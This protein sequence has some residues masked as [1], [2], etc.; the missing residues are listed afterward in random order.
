MR[1]KGSRQVLLPSP[2]RP[3]TRVKG[4][5]LRSLRGPRALGREPSCGRTRSCDLMKRKRGGDEYRKLLSGLARLGESWL[6]LVAPHSLHATCGLHVFFACLILKQ[7]FSQVRDWRAVALLTHFGLS[8]AYW[9]WY[10]L[11]RKTEVQQALPIPKRLCLE[12]KPDLVESSYIS[13][14]PFLRSRPQSAF[15]GDFR[16][17]WVTGS[18]L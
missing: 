6:S 13:R 5:G 11:L 3:C 18:L 7:H 9:Y 1:G 2:P 14:L 15:G 8:V 4:D 16:M 10:T 12:A 17:I